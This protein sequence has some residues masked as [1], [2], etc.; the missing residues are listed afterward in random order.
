ML[1]EKY[2]NEYEEVENL[3]YKAI[4]GDIY[5]I[6]GNWNS[7]YTVDTPWDLAISVYLKS[8][9]GLK[10]AKKNRI[11]KQIF[12]NEKPFPYGY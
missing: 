12:P 1:P 10:V 4:V 6:N 5:T 2:K 8:Y 11:P 9:P 7:K 3:N